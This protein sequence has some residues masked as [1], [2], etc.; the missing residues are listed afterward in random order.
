MSNPSNT[1]TAITDINDLQYH[2]NPGETLSF[3][4]RRPKDLC[5]YV[6]GAYDDLVSWLAKRVYE[7]YYLGKNVRNFITSGAQG[8]GQ[9]AFWAVE[10]MRRIHELD[11]ISNIVF[12]VKGQDANWSKQ[13]SPFCADEYA[14]M[15]RMAN[16]VLWIEGGAIKA[17]FECNHQLAKNADY[18]LA[19]YPDGNWGVGTGGTSECMRFAATRLKKDGN[20]P[21]KEMSRISYTLKK[22]KITPTDI[23]RC[24]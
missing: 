20:G 18:V 22:D 13:G 8:F 2:L 3:I 24:A 21:I 4:G 6:K 11:D 9:L 19:L 15:T 7:D 17:L 10:H 1:I 12:C 5:G 16:L 23:V 14:R